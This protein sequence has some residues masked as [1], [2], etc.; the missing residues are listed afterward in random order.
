LV[1]AGGIAL[2]WLHS[3]FFLGDGPSIRGGLSE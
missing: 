1:F 2:Q 3:G